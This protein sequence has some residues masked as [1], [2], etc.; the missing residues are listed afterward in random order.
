MMKVKVFLNNSGHIDK[1]EESINIWLKENI[2]NYYR[3]I[4]DIRYSSNYDDGL[5]EYVLSA[6]IL[7]TDEEVECQELEVST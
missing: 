3:R 1:F 7:Y 4:E 2:D 6:I 5:D